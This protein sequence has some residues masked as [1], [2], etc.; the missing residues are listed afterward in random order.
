MSSASARR[1]HTL[2][3]LLAATTLLAV[4]LT[5]ALRIMRDSL[6]QDRRIETL[7]LL[8]TFCA[9]KLE[10]HMAQTAASWSVA[11]TTGNFA[12]D[13]CAQIRFSV[14]CTD[15]PAAG[16]ITDR[17][18]ALTATVWEDANSNATLDSGELSVVFRTKV[19]KLEG[20]PQ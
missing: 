14:A 19:A 1:G 12:S 8:T 15:D 7:E 11:T 17:L 10:E 9:D 4:A 5:P 18:M 6:E 2:V 16:G 13:G 3:E 20:Y